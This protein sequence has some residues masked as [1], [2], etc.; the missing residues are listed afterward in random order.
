MTEPQAADWGQ[1]GQRITERLYELGWTQADL[2]R[3]SNISDTQ[4]RKFITGTITGSPRASTLRRIEMALDWP[5]GAIAEIL[6]T[7]D[8]A[9]PETGSEPESGRVRITLHPDDGAAVS[10]FMSPEEA[11]EAAVLTLLD[12]SES[13]EDRTRILRDLIEVMTSS[14]RDAEAA[15]EARRAH[16]R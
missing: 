1:V 16:P 12:G 10:R 9:W 15:A 6:E 14:L 2:V 13:P 3:R 8:L 5:A 7:G 4:L 11:A